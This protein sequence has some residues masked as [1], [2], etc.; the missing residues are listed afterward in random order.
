MGATPTGYPY[1][2]FISRTTEV[3]I[4]MVTCEFTDKQARDIEA[5]LGYAD[6]QYQN[7]LTFKTLEMFRKKTRLEKETT[8][9]FM[10]WGVSRMGI[11]KRDDEET[12]VEELRR[13]V[14]T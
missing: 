12:Y 9:S 3:L 6:D 4:T 14:G 13:L 11:E 5:C 1:E 7:D 10:Q 2:T 8:A